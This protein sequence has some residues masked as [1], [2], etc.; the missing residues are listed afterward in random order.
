MGVFDNFNMT[1]DR[2]SELLKKYRNPV[3]DLTPKVRTEAEPETF[4]TEGSPFKISPE[5]KAKAVQ[6]LDR[7]KEN[8][9]IGD[10]IQGNEG[11]V[12]EIYNDVKK[13]PTFG[14]GHLLTAKE[15]LEIQNITDPKELEFLSDSFFEKDLDDKIKLTKK[16]V[17]KYDSFPIDIKKVLVDSVFRGGLSGSPKTLELI[18]AGDFNNAAIEFLDNKEYRKALKPEENMGGIAVRMKATANALEGFGKTQ[19]GESEI[20][21]REDGKQVSVLKKNIYRPLTPE[22]AKEVIEK[23]IAD[24]TMPE[25][26]AKIALRTAGRT[27]LQS[28]PLFPVTEFALPK[29]EQERATLTK[30]RGE[31]RF[32]AALEG[33]LP[34]E[35]GEAA[36][37]KYPGATMTGKIAQLA[38]LSFLTAG[39]APAVTKFLSSTPLTL[40]PKTIP[41]I[42]GAVQRSATWGIGGIVDIIGR[43]PSMNSITHPLSEGVF[44]FMLGAVH[45]LPTAGAR[46]GAAA[47]ARGGWTAI[48]EL[49]HD[50]NIDKRDLVDIALNASLGAVFEAIN[51]KAVTRRYKQARIDDFLKRKGDLKYNWQGSKVG[52]EGQKLLSS[53]IGK[54]DKT[55]RSFRNPVHI[56]MEGKIPVN[57]T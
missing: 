47:T 19:Q 35:Q 37:K 5:T 50:G 14:V 28:S 21:T 2:F 15:A 22:I 17:P 13:N 53:I 54:L 29:S 20:L 27:A 1:K 57:L 23:K 43:E 56:I 51:A 6:V 12:L 26:L 40:F 45:G 41:M 44:G 46:I 39:T 48:K 9:T 25:S 42:A 36:R 7:F 30:I 24:G 55:S 3:Q 8:R 18:N 38:T 31:G 33:F 4:R 11:R 52:A 16:L 32:N 49:L 34:S 10:Y